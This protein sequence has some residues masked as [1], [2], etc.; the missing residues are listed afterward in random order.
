MLGVC[1]LLV[2]IVTV[3]VDGSLEGTPCCTADV[4]TAVDMS[5]PKV[6]DLEN[7]VADAS[8]AIVDAPG[9]FANAGTCPT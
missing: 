8:F 3:V 1:E 5:V 6:N 2:L 7:S 4:G 9:S